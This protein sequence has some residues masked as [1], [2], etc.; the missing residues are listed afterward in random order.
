MWHVYFSH[1]SSCTLLATENRQWKHSRLKRLKLFWLDQIESCLVAVLQLRIWMVIAFKTRVFQC[2]LEDSSFFLL[3]RLPS[4]QGH[5]QK[6]IIHC[7]TS[8]PR[9]SSHL[10]L[11]L[12]LNSRPITMENL[13]TFILFWV[14]LYVFNTW[15]RHYYSSFWVFVVNL[16]FRLINM[17]YLKITHIILQNN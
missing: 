10:F 15:S 4:K 2:A 9:S 11:S 7:G 6:S 16:S 8:S 13:L 3:D 1:F 17:K 5:G 12:N 14:S